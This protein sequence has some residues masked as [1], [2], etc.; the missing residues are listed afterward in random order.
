M[1]I[2][3]SLQRKGTHPRKI[4]EIYDHKHIP[5]VH[6]PCN[7]GAYATKITT[8]ARVV[9]LSCTT[10]AIQVHTPLTSQAHTCRAQP[11]QYKY[12]RHFDHV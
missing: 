4:I 10:L 7:T 3:L 9:H 11:L 1:P 5:V 12:I 8:G 2:R 6:N